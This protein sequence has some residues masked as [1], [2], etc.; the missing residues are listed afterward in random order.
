M[1]ARTHARTHQSVFWALVKLA[2]LNSEQ[3]LGQPFCSQKK[4]FCSG[5]HL[6][7]VHGMHPQWWLKNVNNH[8]LMFVFAVLRCF[9]CGQEPGLTFISDLCQSLY[10]PWHRGAVWA[11]EQQ[12]GGVEQ[13]TL[14]WVA[15]VSH[16][17]RYTSQRSPLSF[18]LLWVKT[19]QQKG[20]AREGGVWIS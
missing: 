13:S 2:K 10:L 1:H 4:M 14:G 20:T 15:G 7:A 8:I 9:L 11:P 18:H 5:T 3:P 19:S 12:D 17:P 6:Y 16:D